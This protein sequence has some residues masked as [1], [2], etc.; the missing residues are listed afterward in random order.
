MS[1]DLQIGPLGW[2][3]L[4]LVACIAIFFKFSRLWS[5]RNLD[6]FLLFLLTPGIVTL[7][8]QTEEPP[9]IAFVWLCVGSA[10]WLARCLVDL[11][12]SR[13]PLLEPN[14]DAAGLASLSVGVMALLVAETV[15]LPLAAGLARNPAEPI[16]RSDPK[17]EGDVEPMPLSPALPITVDAGILRW[18]S[19]QIILSRVLALVGHLGIVLAILAVGWRHFGRR[20]AGLAAASCYL[21][22]PYTRIEIVDSGQVVPAALIVG[23]IAMFERPWLAGLLIGLAGGWMPPCLGLIPLW[24]GFYWGRGARAFLLGSIGVGA[25]CGVMGLVLTQGFDEWARSLGARSLAEAGLIPGIAAP[26][27]G[28]IWSGIDPAFR[29]PVLVLYTAFIGVIAFWPTGKNLGELIAL[30]AA[31]LLA[32]QFWYLEKGG[33]LVLL[34]LPIF[35]L[36]VFRPNLGH[37]RPR[38]RRRAQAEEAATAT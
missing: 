1:A 28:S 3:V 33:A 32:S 21:L 8:G 10:L 35:L 14:L 27:S 9:W 7:V 23:A 15:T 29:L 16:S 37:K 2:I 4:A 31:V 38:S 5:L 20:I 13:R 34:Y 19:T 25:T 36:M 12:I 11:G 26:E 22:L 18:R 24:A 6:L 17:E 30:S